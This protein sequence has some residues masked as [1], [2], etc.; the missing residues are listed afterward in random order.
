MIKNLAFGDTLLP[1]EFTIGLT[2][3]QSEVSVWLHG[4]GMPRDVTARHTTACTAPLTICVAS[5]DWQ[6]LD[7]KDLRKVSLKFCERGGYERVLGE[8]RLNFNTVISI[9]DLS[10]ILFGV[11]GSTNYCLPKARLWA[12]YLLHAYSQLRR[13]DPPDM[14]MTLLE[15]RAASVT[16]IRPHP[17]SLVSVGDKKN[18]NIFPMNL[19]G[20]L[21]NGYFGFALRE[22][23]L[24]APLV[25]SGGRIAISGVPLAQCSLPFRL[26]GNHKKQSIDWN[27]LPFE[28]KPSVTFGIPVPSFATRVRE[29]RIEK[30]HK[31]GGHRFF[32]ARIISDETYMTGPRACVVH[33]FYQ[34]WRLRGDRATLRA[35]VVEDSMN[36]RGH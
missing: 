33:G 20:E 18:G 31:I 19:M 8:I 11:R 3:P 6:G 25:E 22:R 24:A 32:I 12:H 1:Q 5:D 29:M 23:R 34:F 15:Q 16:F 9:G 21:G 26:A 10:F 2:E 14:K 35:S 4:M 7:E 36:K 17:L 28:T 13:T 30:V 27:E